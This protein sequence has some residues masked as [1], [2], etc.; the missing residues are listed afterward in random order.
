MKAP[1]SMPQRDVVLLCISCDMKAKEDDLQNNFPAD[2]FML[3]IR[4]LKI[5]QKLHI[6]QTWDRILMPA[7]TIL[8]KVIKTI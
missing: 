6:G 3:G 1:V 2:G 8:S 7:I 4:N 5:T